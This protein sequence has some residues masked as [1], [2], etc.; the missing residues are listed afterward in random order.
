MSAVVT[1]DL[2]VAC[3]VKNM[4][5]I[6]NFHVVRRVRISVVSS[7]NMV[8]CDVKDPRIKSRCEH[9]CL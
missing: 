7:G 9:L 2:V 8:N 5:E 6:I 1:L 3:Y 4:S